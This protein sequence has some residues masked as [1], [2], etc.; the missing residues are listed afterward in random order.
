MS[1]AAKPESAIPSLC[2]WAGGL[3]AFESLTN[4]FYGRVKDA[5]DDFPP[6]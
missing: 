3:P 4:I 5:A 1:D 2:E 6:P